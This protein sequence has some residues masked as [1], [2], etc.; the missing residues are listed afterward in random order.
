MGIVW[1]PLTIRGSHYWGK[2]K[3][4]NH[5]ELL[6]TGVLFFLPP[7]KSEKTCNVYIYMSTSQ[8]ENMCFFPISCFFSNKTNPS[9]NPGNS[10]A[11]GLSGHHLVDE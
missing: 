3:P 4:P 7:L 10:S 1:V 5:D 6:V 8:N 11:M 2:H 9:K